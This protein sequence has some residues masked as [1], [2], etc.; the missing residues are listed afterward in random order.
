[1]NQLAEKISDSELDV[2]KVLWEA[3]DALPVTVIREKLQERKGWEAT[4]VKTLVSRLLG[5]GVIA[6]EK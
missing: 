5:K 1:M 2:M 3:E 6:Q 4:T